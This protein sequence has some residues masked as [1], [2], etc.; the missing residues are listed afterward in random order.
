MVICTFNKKEKRYQIIKSTNHL[1]AISQ[2]LAVTYYTLLEIGKQE[3]KQLALC[4]NLAPPEI[5]R[6]WP[7]MNAASSEARKSAAFATSSGLAIRCRG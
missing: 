2:P 7:V 4:Y 5:S 3:K 1:K 6:T